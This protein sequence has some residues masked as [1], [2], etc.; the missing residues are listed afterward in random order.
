MGMHTV[1]HERVMPFIILSTRDEI[2]IINNVV[3]TTPN[4]LLSNLIMISLCSHT[5]ILKRYF[6]LNTI[7]DR[8]HLR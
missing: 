7:I 1:M 2:I 5:Y 6:K 4:L 3:C 8:F